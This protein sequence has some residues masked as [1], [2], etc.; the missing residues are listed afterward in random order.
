MGLPKY[1]VNLNDEERARLGALLRGGTSSARMQTRA[2]V[3]LKADDGL[4]DAEIVEALGI[5]IATVH[6]IRQRCVEGGFE[7]ALIEWKRPGMPPKFTSKQQAA[8]ARDGAR[9]Q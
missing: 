9:L 7:S 2:G 6:R 1:I 5:G 3:L 8:R 4:S